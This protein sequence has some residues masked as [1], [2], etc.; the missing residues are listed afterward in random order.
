[1]EPL[2]VQLV[3]GTQLF[4]SK[5]CEYGVLFTHCAIA[6]FA[7][8]NKVKMTTCNQEFFIRAMI[9]QLSYRNTNNELALVFNELENYQ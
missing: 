4:P 6:E 5:S 9:P 7:T 1:M 8:N 3:W 2:L